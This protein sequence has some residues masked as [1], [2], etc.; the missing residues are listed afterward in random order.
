LST[1]Q[2]VYFGENPEN[3]KSLA[4]I[5]GQTGA[6]H[7]SPACVCCLATSQGCY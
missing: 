2:L 4:V 1:S 5:S 7:F 3:K 6:I